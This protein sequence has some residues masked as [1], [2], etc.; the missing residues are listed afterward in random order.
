MSTACAV[1]AVSA[2][3]SVIQKLEDVTKKLDML[4]RKMNSVSVQSYPG[5]GSTTQFAQGNPRG[6][7][8]RSEDGKPICHYCHK[9]GHIERYC[10]SKQGVQ[11]QQ[12]G[13]GQ[14]GL[15]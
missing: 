9:I 4:E 12:R 6:S 14:T 15:N 13:G 7:G 10:Y 1:N 11:Q 3:A 5:Q 8:L 2:D